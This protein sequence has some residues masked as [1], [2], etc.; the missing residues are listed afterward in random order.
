VADA[1]SH[2]LCQALDYIW[3]DQIETGKDKAKEFL[4]GIN[5]AAYITQTTSSRRP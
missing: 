2:P 3:W 5:P 4:V 1:P